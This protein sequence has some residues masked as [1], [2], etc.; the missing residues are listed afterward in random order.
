MQGSSY[1]TGIPHWPDSLLVP[2]CV[3]EMSE[4]RQHTH[5]REQTDTVRRVLCILSVEYNKQIM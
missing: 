2:V 5:T 1:K 3:L 4:L